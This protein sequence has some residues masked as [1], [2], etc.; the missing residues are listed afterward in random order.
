MP[1]KT[2]SR[3]QQTS[4]SFSFNKY[5]FYILPDFPTKAVT[6]LRVAASKYGSIG[7]E[8][9]SPKVSSA[10]SLCGS[11]LVPKP[12]AIVVAGVIFA[13][14]LASSAEL[15]RPPFVISDSE[16]KHRYEFS[17]EFL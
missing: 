15:C 7:G 13:W 8:C 1:I 5:F 14:P 16:G 12:L 2:K 11:M 6:F 3:Y 4:D 9:V 17:V 10:C